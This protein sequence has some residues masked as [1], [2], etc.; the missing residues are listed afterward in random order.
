M[1]HGACAQL[2]RGNSP[3]NPRTRHIEKSVLRAHAKPEIQFRT[4]DCGTGRLVH[5]NSPGQMIQGTQ[6]QIAQL[7]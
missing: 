7:S 5:E 6:T 3:D 1:F 2:K 4:Q